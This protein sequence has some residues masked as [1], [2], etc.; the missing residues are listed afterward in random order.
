MSGAQVA[1]YLEEYAKHFELEQHVL[2]NTTVRR[3]L[4]DELDRGWNVYVC[5][6][7]GDAILHFDKVVLGSG[8]DSVPSWLQMPGRDLFKGTV[9]HGQSYRRYDDFP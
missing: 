1:E 8:S 4:R 7:E 6:P 9:I 3:I 5:G 2:F